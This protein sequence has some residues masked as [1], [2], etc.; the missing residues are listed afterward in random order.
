[1]KK[2]TLLRFGHCYINREGDFAIG[3]LR[4]DKKHGYELAASHA[5]PNILLGK[6]QLQSRIIPNDGNWIEI[7]PET[8]NIASKLHR[9]GQKIK[10]PAI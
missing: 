8:F 2:F 6:I 10:F 4:G 9:L 5:H 3:L 7:H 1:M